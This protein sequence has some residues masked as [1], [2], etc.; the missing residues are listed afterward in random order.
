M[1]SMKPVVEAL[2]REINRLWAL[3]NPPGAR[4]LVP[5]PG[6]TTDED[7]Q[8]PAQAAVEKWLGG[9]EKSVNLR[10]ESKH[11]MSKAD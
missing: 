4:P 6:E 7:G 8:T 3:Q 10:P 5:L 11:E 2:G 1:N 9:L